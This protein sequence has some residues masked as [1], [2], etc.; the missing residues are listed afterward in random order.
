MRERKRKR[1]SPIVGEVDSLS[2]FPGDERIFSLLFVRSP[3]SLPLSVRPHIYPHI[4]IESYLLPSLVERHSL[5]F[6]ASMT[7]NGSARLES[8]T[9]VVKK[10]STKVELKKL[11]SLLPTLKQKSSSSPIEIVLETI[12]YIRELEDQLIDRFQIDALDSSSSSSSS[13]SGMFLID[14]SILNDFNL[15]VSFV[16]RPSL[17]DPTLLRDIGNTD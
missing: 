10:D 8:K 12:R 14:R 1:K 2:L 13:H 11:K 5:F 3:L 9:K 6:V 4:D 17:A 15:L 16:T 7:R